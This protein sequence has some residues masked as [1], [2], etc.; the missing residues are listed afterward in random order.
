MIYLGITTIKVTLYLP[1]TGSR[2]HFRGVKL[3]NKEQLKDMLAE[4]F[5]DGTISINAEFD[6]ILQIEVGGECVQVI[7]L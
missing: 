5:R 3:V 6:G 1:T 2:I 4:M 7:R